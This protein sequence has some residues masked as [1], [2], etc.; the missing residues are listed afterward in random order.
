MGILDG[1]NFNAEPTPG[2]S[3][4]FRLL[5]APCDHFVR[6][7]VVDNFDIGALLQNMPYSGSS[8]PPKAPASIYNNIAY[9]QSIN[10]DSSTLIKTQLPY[11]NDGSFMMLQQIDKNLL[12]TENMTIADTTSFTNLQFPPMTNTVK[13]KLKSFVNATEYRLIDFNRYTLSQLYGQVKFNDVNDIGQ[14]IVFYYYPDKKVILSKN[15]AQQFNYEFV[16]L[17]Q[18]GRGI[19]KVY[20]RAI[21]SS[22]SNILLRYRTKTLNCTKCLGQNSVND[23]V[24]NANGRIQEVYDFSKM[25]QDFFKRLLTEKGS[26]ILDLNEG[27]QIGILSGMAKANPLLL[28]TLIKN[29]IID[30]LSAIRTKQGT[31]KSLQGISL[32]EQIYQINRVDVRSINATDI[33]VEIEVL[34]L[35]GQSEQIKAIIRR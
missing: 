15:Q 9:S 2:T 33:G 25:I 4:D 12:I 24:F 19:F 13:A 26:N 14:Q 16:N 11:V 22:K 29:Q 23:I 20:G 7:E 32:A 10:P 35:A 21:S 5:D 17:D 34:S 27:S 6:N 18:Q 8:W 30:I 1:I 31:Q 28:E 3:I